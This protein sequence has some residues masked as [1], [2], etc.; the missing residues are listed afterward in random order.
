MLILQKTEIYTRV[1]NMWLPIGTNMLTP[2]PEVNPK[3]AQSTI[4]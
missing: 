4:P 3:S 2:P 1:N